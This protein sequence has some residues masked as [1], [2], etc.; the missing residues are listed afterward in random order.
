MPWEI[1]SV[2]V[3]RVGKSR[4]RPIKM[5]VAVR[6]INWSLAARRGVVTKSGW[7]WC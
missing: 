7:G 3:W 1:S 5:S 2:A 4:L 6:G